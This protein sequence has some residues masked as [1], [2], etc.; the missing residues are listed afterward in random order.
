MY[1]KVTNARYTHP[2]PRARDMQILGGIDGSA[3]DT[4][5]WR[6]LCV[7]EVDSAAMTT[8]P[9]MLV[10]QPL[11]PHADWDAPTGEVSNQ[12]TTS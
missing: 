9:M 10:L 2:P 8:A 5:K 3:V 6:A 4:P 1:K 11:W 12:Q 7:D